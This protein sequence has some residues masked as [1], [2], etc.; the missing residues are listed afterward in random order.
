MHTVLEC[1]KFG[2]NMQRIKMFYTNSVSC[3]TGNGNLSTGFTF[4]MD[5]D[6]V[7]FYLLIYLLYV[8]RF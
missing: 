8:L 6:T 4:I 5:A 1:F 2:P 3:V 7:T